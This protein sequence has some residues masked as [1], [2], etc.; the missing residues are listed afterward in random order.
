MLSIN[1]NS[2]ILPMLKLNYLN[3]IYM[4]YLFFII[5]I[6]AIFFDKNTIKN[7]KITSINN[8]K[9]RKKGLLTQDSK[10]SNSEFKK[11]QLVKE[12]VEIEDDEEIQQEVMQ[13][14]EEQVEEEQVEEESKIEYNDKLGLTEENNFLKFLSGSSNVRE[15]FMS[16]KD[17]K[18]NYNIIK[19]YNDKNLVE[20]DEYNKET[21]IKD[22]NDIDYN[23]ENVKQL[24][25]LYKPENKKFNYELMEDKNSKLI[26]ENNNLMKK[27]NFVLE[28]LTGEDL[29]F[30][31][32]DK[33]DTK[34]SF[35]QKDIENNDIY[36]NKD[37]NNQK[38][39][40]TLKFDYNK[41][42][43]NKLKTV[44]ENQKKIFFN[45]SKDKYNILNNIKNN[46]INIYN[47]N[48]KNN[49][50]INKIKFN[51][52]LKNPKPFQ[53]PKLNTKYNP[54]LP[55][56]DNLDSNQSIAFKDIDNFR[57]LKRENLN[58]IGTIEEVSNNFNSL[59]VNNVNLETIQENTLVSS[60]TIF[61]NIK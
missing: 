29:G 27:S 31:N 48:Y 20:R 8:D 42:I 43:N 34:Y 59:L 16:E 17:F 46:D 38:N 5:L 22:K 24:D 10:I 2:L 58:K 35:F 36:E 32:I 51:K 56:K 9:M 15:N 40:Y 25:Y 12:D 50:G 52:N 33:I 6:F 4:E 54:I 3:N 61:K 57:N 55:H 13:V 18:I 44:S 53:R 14:E 19:D 23:Y 37:Y 21:E 11:I 49:N 30:S 45:K 60:K 26:N 7:T 28:K 47:S 39:I 1:K 41:K